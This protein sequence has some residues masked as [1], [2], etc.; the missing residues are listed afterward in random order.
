MA[1]RKR[2]RGR[3]ARPGPRW[4]PPRW[5]PSAGPVQREPR[6]RWRPGY[7]LRHPAF[8]AF[9]FGCGVLIA[10]GCGVGGLVDRHDLRARGVTTSAVTHEVAESRSGVWMTVRITTER[11]EVVTARVIRTPDDLPAV[12]DR[13]TVVYDPE[14]PDDAYIPGDEGAV[15]TPVLFIG[16]GLVAG[17]LYGWYLRRTWSHWR[18]QAEDWRHHRPVPRLGEKQNPWP[19]RKRRA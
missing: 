2:R 18:D 19:D 12:G 11:G 4:T 3:G 6:S 8:A 5:A 14:D 7:W 10:V 13:L 17:G 16:L 15:G 9:L 1:S